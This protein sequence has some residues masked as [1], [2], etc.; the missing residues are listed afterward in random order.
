MS[1]EQEQRIETEL[2][3]LAESRSEFV[4]RY[5]GCYCRVNT[6][7]IIMEVRASREEHTFCACMV[8]VAA[9]P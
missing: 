8:R 2:M 6:L 5:H 9:V 7:N 4:V 1:S 3:A